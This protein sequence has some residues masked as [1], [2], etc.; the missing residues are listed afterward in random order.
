MILKLEPDT[1]HTL[2]L[3]YP[4]GRQVEGVYGPQLLWTLAN[5]DRLYTPLQ[6]GPQIEALGIRPGEPFVLTKRRNG[7]AFN[8]IA[9]RTTDFSPANEGC[10][11]KS[12]DNIGAHDK[13]APAHKTPAPAHSGPP[14][15]AI[16]HT[17][18]ITPARL[19]AA[20]TAAI[21]AAA[22]V[23][24][25]AAALGYSC[26]FSSADISAM[27]LSVLKKEGSDARL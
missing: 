14:A 13:P 8:W 15:P 22:A 24:A 4:A 6:V 10:F 2:T 1:P 20:L 19:Q 18:A 9:S 11:A 7:R 27:G 25:H 26:K 5:G 3:K 17:P 12:P 23:E 16:E 21:R